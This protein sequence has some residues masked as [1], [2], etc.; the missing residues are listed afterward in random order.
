MAPVRKISSPGELRKVIIEKGAV[1]MIA[2]GFSM[3]LVDLLVAEYAWAVSGFANGVT[4]VVAYFLCR[5]DKHQTAFIMADIATLLNLTATGLYSNN[6]GENFLLVTVLM[7]MF[8]VD[9]VGLRVGISLL[10]LAG[11]VGVKALHWQAAEPHSA[12]LLSYV[13]RYLMFATAYYLFLDYFRREQLHYQT[14]IEANNRELERQRQQLVV[15]SAELQAS[16]R[17]KEKLFS[18]VAHDFQ[19]P[20][21]GIKSVLDCLESGELNQKDYEDFR[22]DFK[23][24]VDQLL[25]SMRNVCTWASGQMGVLQARAEP[26]GLWAAAGEAMLLLD[27]IARAKR[28]GVENRIP[29]G[30]VVIADKQEVGAVMR[31]LL[32]NALKFTPAGGRVI[33]EAAAGSAAQRLWTVSVQDTGI[34]MDAQAAA[35]IFQEGADYR[36]TPGTAQ[37]KGFGLGLQ[38]CRDFVA[39]NGGRIWVE[40]RPGAGSRFSFTLP[41]WGKG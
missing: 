41:A 10:A 21:C 5:K 13:L 39:G 25:F 15:R 17:A 28:V 7:T 1:L 30:A 14:T 16:N 11:Y 9:A 18:I 23:T 31:N 29:S 37:E 6:S 40:S 27:Q 32:A 19:G 33:F 26:V 38:I 20:L 34:G 12:S 24:Q 36:S 3:T 35:G 4:G 22:Q 8:M 2:L